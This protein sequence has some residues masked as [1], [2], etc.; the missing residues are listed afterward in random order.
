MLAGPSCARRLAC[1]SR[2]LVLCCGDAMWK[3]LLTTI[4]G[5]CI[6]GGGERSQRNYCRMLSGLSMRES[7]QV[8]VEMLVWW[9]W[10]QRS[11]SS[12]FRIFY[13]F[14]KKSRSHRVAHGPCMAE[15]I[16]L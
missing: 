3:Y 10:G 13:S 11:C 6:L 7:A 9:W 8:V 5:A 15:L 2:V 14:S 16:E 4:T 1:L 12:P